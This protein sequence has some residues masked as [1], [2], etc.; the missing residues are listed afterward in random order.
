MQARNPFAVP[1]D[2]LCGVRAAE[3]RVEHV[4]LKAHACGVRRTGQRLEQRAFGGRYELVTMAV[5]REAQALIG[6]G[7]C[8]LVESLGGPERIVPGERVDMWDPRAHDPR[9]PE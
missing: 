2:E 7:C 3:K 6:R 8:E 5:V 9:G 4:D 1:I